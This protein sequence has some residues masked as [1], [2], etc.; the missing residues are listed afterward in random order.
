MAGDRFVVLGL[1]PARR[2][3][4][5]ALAQWANSAAVLVMAALGAIMWVGFK[6]I[7]GQ[8]SSNTSTQVQCVGGAGG[9][10]CAQP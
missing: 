10:N 1:A 5:R 4:F 7:F 2:E 6:A 9:G 8:A 3:W